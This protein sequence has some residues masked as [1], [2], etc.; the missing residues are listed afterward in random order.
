MRDEITASALLL[1]TSPASLLL[2]QRK[3]EVEHFREKLLLKE[4]AWSLEVGLGGWFQ[5]WLTLSGPCTDSSL[6]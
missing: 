2:A 3:I 1:F 6:L 5:T 4:G